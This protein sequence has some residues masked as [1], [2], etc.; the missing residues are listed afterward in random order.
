M[1]GVL[2]LNISVSSSVQSTLIL[3]GH[4]IFYIFYFVSEILILH[5][6]IFIYFVQFHGDSGLKFRVQGVAMYIEWYTVDFDKIA[7]L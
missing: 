4:P 2:L 7:M 6:L 5:K 1:S 3:K